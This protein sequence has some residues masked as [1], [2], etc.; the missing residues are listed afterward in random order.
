MFY[1]GNDIFN[2]ILFFNYHS[3]Q[4]ENVTNN[5]IYAMSAIIK[6]RAVE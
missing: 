3:R 6:G 1:T 4:R 5:K 2:D